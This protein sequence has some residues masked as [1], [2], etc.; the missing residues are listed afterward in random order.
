LLAE[1]GKVDWLRIIFKT[2]SNLI[3]GIAL[4]SF[5]VSYKPWYGEYPQ[6]TGIIIV[7][8]Y[9]GSR[10]IDLIADRLVKIIEK[11]MEK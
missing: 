7:L 3:A 6:K 10:G 9:A 4:Y 2:V 5:L 1:E 8:V 11:H